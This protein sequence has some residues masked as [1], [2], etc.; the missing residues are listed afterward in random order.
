MQI[1]SAC[2]TFAITAVRRFSRSI[3]QRSG[4]SFLSNLDRARL[5]EIVSRNRCALQKIDNW[6][7]PGIIEKSV[8]RYGITPQVET[9][10]NLPL[11]NRCTHADLLAYLACF[12]SLR[13]ESCKYLELGVSVGKTIW[14]ILNT[15]APCAC[16]GLDIEEINPALRRQLDE[17]SREEWPTPADSIKSTPSSIS[18]F[19]HRPSGSKVTYIC[20]D[21]YDERAWQLLSGQQFNL[22]FSDAL[23]STEAL[24]FEWRHMVSDEILAPGG[25]A[26]MWD[27]LDGPMRKWFNG[28]RDAIAAQLAVDR[29]QVITLY[30][31]GWLGQR[32]WPHRLGLAFR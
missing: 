4:R 21:I 11:D 5:Q 20:A 7:P 26:I 19:I 10:L 18:R 6:L 17:Q 12:G 14:Q 24:D 3:S 16:W 22:V 13:A 15:C 31:N 32:E 30:C 28:K 29:K 1:V 2:K 8:F 9:A 25:L 23:H 27:D